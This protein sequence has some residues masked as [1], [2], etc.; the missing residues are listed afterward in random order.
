M[1]LKIIKLIDNFRRYYR[2]YKMLTI[3]DGWKKAAWLKKHK[4]FYHIGDKVYYTPNILPAEPFLVCLHNNVAIS[5]GV[6]LITH[7]IAATV[8]NNEEN[9]KKYI[10][11]FGKIEILDNVYIGANVCVNPGVTIG[12]N[13]IVAAGAVVTKDVPEGTVV[14]G[15]PA[16]VIGSYEK[17]KQKTLEKSQ[18]YN[19]IQSGDLFVKDLLELS[20]IEFLIDSEGQKV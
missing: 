7:S 15:V 19:G 10:T 12:P 8:F 2:Q 5:A 6:R 17:V 20:P 13:A 14:G 1:K 3:R 4:V 16:V 9:T 11:D 18:K